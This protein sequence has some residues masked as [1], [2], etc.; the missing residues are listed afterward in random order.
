LSKALEHYREA[1]NIARAAN[2]DNLFYPAMNRMSIELRL[3]A[4]SPQ[5]AQGFDAADVSAVRQSLQKKNVED[6]DFWSAV[7]SV[8]L[9]I[10]EALAQGRLAPALAVIL[11]DL[12]DV[13]RRVTSR[14][15]WDSVT[16]QAR[17]TLNAYLAASG[18]SIAE[19]A[20]VNNLLEQLPGSKAA[21]PAAKKVRAR[22][23]STRRRAK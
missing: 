1:E 12:D 8:E 9:T 19:R 7:G 10:Y 5:A 20:A 4:G 3:R 2:A 11:A 21:A 6:P 15:S 14:L 23:K 18:L 16:Y 17:L 22:K 13:K